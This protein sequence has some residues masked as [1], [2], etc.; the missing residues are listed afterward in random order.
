[1]ATLIHTQSHG[2][3]IKT[4]MFY[5][6][7]PMIGLK[8]YGA[9]LRTTRPY[10]EFCEKLIS[11]LAFMYANDRNAIECFR[12][13]DHFNCTRENP[14]LVMPDHFDGTIHVQN[15]INNNLA[16]FPSR[17]GDIRRFTLLKPLSQHLLRFGNTPPE[18][19]LSQFPIQQPSLLENG[20]P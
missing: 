15:E 19:F 17:V 10:A 2:N 18:I 9:T 1:M 7:R 12:S 8:I 16:I 6:F 5:D 11:R 3:A 4:K 20:P 13:L 14:S